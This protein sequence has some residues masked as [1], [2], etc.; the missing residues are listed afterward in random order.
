MIS[1]DDFENI[2]KRLQADNIKIQFGVGTM[3][4]AKNYVGK[5]GEPIVVKDKELFAICNGKDTTNRKYYPINKNTKPPIG[6][7]IDDYLKDLVNWCLENTYPGFLTAEFAKEGSLSRSKLVQAFENTKKFCIPDGRPL[8]DNCFVKENFGISYAPNLSGR[9]LRHY[10]SGGSTDSSGSRSLGHEQSDSLKSHRHYIDRSK[11]ERIYGQLVTRTESIQRTSDWSR[12]NT[13]FI[14]QM[15]VGSY[16]DREDFPDRTEYE[17]S[18]ET[19]PKNTCYI[20][21]YRYDW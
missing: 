4:E 5:L 20:S 1:D 15:L 12:G 6:E 19:R 17:G 8:P 2:K 9:F 18:S 11:L 21:F 7:N 10:D 3:E 14:T 16:I 13:S